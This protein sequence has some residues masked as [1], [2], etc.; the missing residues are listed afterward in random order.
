[1]SAGQE[2]SSPSST[3][4]H[5]SVDMPLELAPT[6]ALAK[7]EQFAQAVQGCAGQD[8]ATLTAGTSVAEQ[9]GGAAPGSSLAELIQIAGGALKARSFR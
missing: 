5:V 4:S 6:A 8:T 1:M 2:P 9:R 7:F 3:S